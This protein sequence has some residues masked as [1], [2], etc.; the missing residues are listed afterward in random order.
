MIF[1]RND[2]DDFFEAD[3]DII[4]GP[5]LNTEFNDVDKTDLET[6]GW[7]KSDEFDCWCHHC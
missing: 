2:L 6:L 3:H 7:F 5:N 4:Y 1:K